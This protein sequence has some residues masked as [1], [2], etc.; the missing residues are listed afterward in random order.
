MAESLT[1]SGGA[2]FDADSGGV[3]GVARRWY[4]NGMGALKSG[5]PAS[6]AVGAVVGTVFVSAAKY[7][8]DM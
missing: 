7:V 1:T 4:R 2:Y 6:I 3:V 8:R 5:E